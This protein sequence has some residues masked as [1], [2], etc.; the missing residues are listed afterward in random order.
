MTHI[1]ALT[2]MVFATNNAFL[3]SPKAGFDEHFTGVSSTLLHHL[4]SNAHQVADEKNKG[5]RMIHSSDL[6][7]ISSKGTILIHKLGDNPSITTIASL[8]HA[9][10]TP[11]F[12]PSDEGT[13]THP[14]AVC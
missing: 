13:S 9:P 14:V 6:L 8:A 11:C 5:G 4:D 7:F 2:L 1:Q 3:E 12:P 10:G